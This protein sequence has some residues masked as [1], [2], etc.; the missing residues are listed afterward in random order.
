MPAALGILR[1]IIRGIS[2]ETNGDSSLDASVGEGVTRTGFMTPNKTHF[3]TSMPKPSKATLNI[4][5]H[6]GLVLSDFADIKDEEIT[7][8]GDTG[9]TLQVDTMTALNTGPI[10][11][12][13]GTFSLELEGGIAREV[14]T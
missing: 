9:Q 5:V 11:S 12:Q 6:P 13:N 4:V 8:V 1:A 7:F 2:V 3:Y 10:T 14:N